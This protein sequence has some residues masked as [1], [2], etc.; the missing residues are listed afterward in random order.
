LRPKRHRRAGFMGL[1]L[2]ATDGRARRARQRVETVRQSAED[3]WF[4]AVRS[5]SRSVR[6]RVFSSGN[7]CAN[8]QITFD[9]MKS[10]SS[11]I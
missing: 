5:R 7:I 6:P 3:T 4:R 11:P 1:H 9:R 8:L 2:P 10:A